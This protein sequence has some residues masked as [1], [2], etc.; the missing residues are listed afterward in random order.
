MERACER[1]TAETIISDDTTLY[2]Q[3]I[4]NVS[5]GTWTS[6][7][8]LAK[9][10]ADIN[11]IPM[12]VYCTN[13]GCSYCER[14]EKD[15]FESE[16]FAAW[17]QERQFVMV[18]SQG[19][20]TVNQFARNSSRAYPYVAVYWNKGNGEDPLLV[21]YTGRNGMMPWRWGTLTEQFINSV[22]SVLG[23]KEIPD[24]IV[25]DEYL[26]NMGDRIGLI[27]PLDKMRFTVKK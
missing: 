1:V 22:D 19:D 21:K 12:L 6:D 14:L 11:A 27:L 20:S 4:V 23:N 2:A 9:E 15:V 24:F 26:W 7:F 17:C 10:Y 16:Q 18:Y 13:P 5:L 8:A 3:W 25:D